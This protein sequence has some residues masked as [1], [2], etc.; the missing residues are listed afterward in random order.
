ME[1][2][3]VG[4]SEKARSLCNQFGHRFRSVQYT[5]HPRGIEGE[6]Q[7]KSSNL[8]WAANEI[9]KIHST[10][11]RRRTVI[12]NTVVTII[13]ADSQLLAPYFSAITDMHHS[14]PET[15]QTTMYVPP[16]IF[17][18]NCNAVPNLVRIADIFWGA[19]GMSG[20][21]PHAAICP[22]TSV[23][24]LPLSLI[25]RIGGWD[26]GPESIGEDLHM[27]IKCFFAL[28]GNLTARVVPSAASCSN[29][30]APSSGIRDYIR[31][32]IARYNQSL[33]HM[34]GSLDTG[35]AVRRI[36]DLL[37]NGPERD[38]SDQAEE[39]DEKSASP[40]IEMD[41][42]TPVLAPNWI[43]IGTLTERLF[44]AHFLPVHLALL[45]IAS[46]LYVIFRSSIHQAP[47][48]DWVFNITGYLRAMAA[49]GM[50]TFISLYENFHRLNVNYRENEMKKVGLAD[51]MQGG[52]ARRQL[53]PNMLDYCLFPVAGA[54]YGPAPLIHAQI[55]HLW[56][57][58]LVYKV[59]AKP[60]GSPM[61]N[62]IEKIV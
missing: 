45:P 9:L 61:A 26:T 28:N 25:K 19:A 5:V 32:H 56:T 43:N 13:D 12:R 38:E 6:A 8:A 62:I 35:Y 18:R 20:L 47:E 58:D 21:Y 50:I 41:E 42:A 14:Y 23:Y 54:I 55:K 48:L 33:R 37:W 24:S 7:G 27:Y 16:V 39:D 31:A 30:S 44:E 22:P 29:L 10:K 57:V 49:L 2:G 15:A 59:S 11:K 4:S 60:R 36:L 53:W 3:E 40:L 46:L 34:W 51:Q 17:D 52:F 1:E